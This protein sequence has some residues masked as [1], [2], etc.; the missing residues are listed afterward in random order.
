MVLAC[1]SPVVVFAT[2]LFK[3]NLVECKNVFFIKIKARRM[4]LT[5]DHLSM[6]YPVPQLSP[7]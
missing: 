6:G 3:D 1:Q 2:S 5:V 7:E 4:K